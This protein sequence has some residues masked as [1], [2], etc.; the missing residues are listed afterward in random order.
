[1]PKKIPSQSP[2]GVVVYESGSVGY[3][4]GEPRKEEINNVVDIDDVARFCG[5]GNRSTK[6]DSKKTALDVQVNGSHY[7]DFPIQPIEFIHKNNL[8][9][10]QGNV[11]KYICR[12][13]Q[14]GEAEDIRKVI[15]Y[16]QL[17]LELEYG[18][19]Q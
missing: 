17:I 6:A 4:Y 1:M 11:V 16:A 13:R 8:S 12:Y 10:A 18:E 15:H 9:F 5:E 2:E 19:T 7:K 14:K 3:S